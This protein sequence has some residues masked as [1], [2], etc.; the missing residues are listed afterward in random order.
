ML[1]G[2]GFCDKEPGM[3]AYKY[4]HKNYSMT[5]FSGLLQIYFVGLNLRF[6]QPRADKN[7]LFPLSFNNGK[8]IYIIN[9][10]MILT[11]IMKPNGG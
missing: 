5:A 8:I 11:T 1:V 6:G 2:A 3:A 9:A 10:M 7:I 4:L